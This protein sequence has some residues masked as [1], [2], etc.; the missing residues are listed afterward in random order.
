MK[1]THTRSRKDENQA[2]LL[3][4][5]SLI[6]KLIKQGTQVDENTA[7]F[8]NTSISSHKMLRKLETFQYKYKILDKALLYHSKRFSPCVTIAESSLSNGYSNNS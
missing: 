1:L 2:Q 5:I 8:V 3:H 4:L 7:I 6:S